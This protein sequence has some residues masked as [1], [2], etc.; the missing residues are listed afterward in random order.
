MGDAGKDGFRPASDVAFGDV[1]A[2]ER[3]FMTSDECGDEAVT[4]RVGVV[5]RAI[6]AFAD[7]TQLSRIARG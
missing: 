2:F 5:G 1:Q 3:T 6:A 4:P 7:W